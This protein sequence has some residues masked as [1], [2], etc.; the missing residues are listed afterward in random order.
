M[1]D[2]AVLTNDPSLHHILGQIITLYLKEKCW[3]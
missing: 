3:L 1:F 2:N